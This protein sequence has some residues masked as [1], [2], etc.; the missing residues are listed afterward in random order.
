[1]TSFSSSVALQ[2]ERDQI[3][4]DVLENKYGSLLGQRF[5]EVKT[6]NEGPLIMVQ[7]LLRDRDKS[8]FYPM[9]GRINYVDQDMKEHE[10]RG[11]LLDFMD[12]YVQEYLS[13][14]EDAYLTIDWSTYDCDG[15]E[16]QLRG[17]ILN[18]KLESMADAI[19]SGSSVIN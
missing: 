10:A 7:I 12:A 19:L 1:M 13:G 11:F 6:T 14:G 8:Y 3:V 9:E 2:S 5:F 16:L 15:V 18:L 17:Q 4:V